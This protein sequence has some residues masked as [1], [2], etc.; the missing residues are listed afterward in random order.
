MYQKFNDTK[1]LF[2]QLTKKKLIELPRPD[3][4]DEPFSKIP[5]VI[6]D[7]A[8]RGA[9]QYFL[10]QNGK[11]LDVYILNESNELDHYQQSNID[12][13]ELVSRVSHHH[14]FKEFESS[15]QRF[16]LPH[17]FRLIR[18]DGRLRALPFGMSVDDID[19]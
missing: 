13:D 1:A 6:Q 9:I 12:I 3:L 11:E 19:F 16:N 7:F 17:F 15:Q 2:Q 18:V 8:A 10:R 14:A 4:G 5:E